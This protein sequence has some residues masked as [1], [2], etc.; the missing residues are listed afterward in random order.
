[1][2]GYSP[3]QSNLSKKVI[4][5]G[6]GGATCSG[7]TTL[8]K[9]LRSVL[10]GS[11][12]I[13][14]DDFAPPE[15]LVPIH[16]IHNVQDWDDPEGAIDWPRMVT[17]LRRVKETGILP[18]DHKSHDGLNKQDPMPIPQDVLDQ[19]RS[20]FQEMQDS[21]RNSSGVELVWGLVDGF[22]LYWHPGVI[23]ALDTRIFL[24]VSYPTLKARRE[25]RFGYHTAVQF[26]P[27]GSFWRDPPGYWDDI[28]WPAYL[29]A[30]ERIFEGGDIDHGSAALVDDEQTATVSDKA[31]KIKV[32]EQ[33][34]TQG[35][36]QASESKDELSRCGQPV[37]R[38]LVLPAEDLT[39]E[40]LFTAV[41]DRLLSLN[42]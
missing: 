36:M 15:E 27:E 1:M 4:F 11:V 5:I 8:A 39:M 23:Q 9:H 7:K 13:H 24:R 20:R 30:H 41:C 19:W 17:F 6:V 31:M 2:N 21:V 12:I 28:V 29:K 22:L 26:S 34:I 10:P 37:P 3:S 35:E 32:P 42:S 16:P 25:R 14:Q 18:E 40:Q 38:L 33:N